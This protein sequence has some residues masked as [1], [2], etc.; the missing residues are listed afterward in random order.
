MDC[1]ALALIDPACVVF[2]IPGHLKKFKLDLFNRIGSSIERVGGRVV[3]GDFGELAKASLDRTP[4]VGCT[5]ELR[6]LIDEWI[7]ERRGWIYWDRGYARR[8]FATWL[9][10]GENG[11]H[12]RFHVNSYQLQ[13]IRNFPDDRWR[14]LKT[15]VTPWRKNGRH[16]VIAAPTKTYSAF[17]RIE[18]WTDRTIAALAL[19]T[20]RQIVIRDKESRRPLQADLEGAHA[21][22]AHGSIAA[23][24]AAICG[25]PVFVHPDSAASLIGL[26]DLARIEAPICPDRQT[27]LN[28]LAYS[29]FNESELVDGTLWRS[30]Q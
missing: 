26:T 24:E 21:L 28:A 18:G 16:I 30:I 9:P 13:V 12:Y 5:P 10:R 19:V 29:Q 2:F 6:P 27:W 25:C 7:S 14:A 17:H 22:V 20:D 8:V 15:D 1:G 4:I 3:R 11:G 23:V